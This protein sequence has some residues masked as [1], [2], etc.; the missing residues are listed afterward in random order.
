[1]PPKQYL[2]LS[3]VDHLS[4][5]LEEERHG[6]PPSLYMRYL[7]ADGRW[8]VRGANHAPLLVWELV[9]ASDAQAAAD[10]A[11]K[12]R[13]R[14]VEV[15]Q[16]ADSSWEEGKH[17]QQFCIASEPA[18]L[19][20]AAQSEAKARRLRTEAEKLEAMCSVVLA[21]GAAREHASY[22]A[23][24][25]AAASAMRQ[26]FGGGSVSSASAWL[27]GKSGRAALDSVMAGEVDLEG[28]LSLQQLA[29]TVELAREA[30][31]LRSKP[32]ETSK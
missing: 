20:Y 16:R 15:A 9:Q 32:T 3:L 19:G 8:A 14:R 27:A 28:P 2:L 7:N 11:S 30:E 10:R 12:A 18:L 22:E 1:M 13:G 6:G 21:D 17:I 24:S 25:R 31:A 5:P 4:T 29:Q 23:V 26:K